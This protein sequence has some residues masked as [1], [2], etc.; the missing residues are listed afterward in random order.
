MKEITFKWSGAIITGT[1]EAQVFSTIQGQKTEILGDD[2][3]EYTLYGICKVGKCGPFEVLSINDIEEQPN[4]DD[5]AN[6][7]TGDIPQWIT[8]INRNGSK[9]EFDTTAHPWLKTKQEF[10]DEANR[11]ADLVASFEDK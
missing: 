11:L 9:C 6:K 5:L 7:L 4:S 8:V 1:I 10:V 3:V 2:G